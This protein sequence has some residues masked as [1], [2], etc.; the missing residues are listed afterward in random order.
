MSNHHPFGPSS[1]GRRL[2]CPGS[3]KQERDLP[4]VSSTDADLGT[5]IHDHAAK[6]L[7]GDMHVL[8]IEDDD[9]RQVVTRYVEF[10]ES[11][12]PEGAVYDVES[13]Q[14]LVGPGGEVVSFGTID[15]YHIVEGESRQ[16]MVI[17]LKSGHGEISPVDVTLQLGSYLAY[18][19]QRFGLMSAR[20]WI[21]HAR[22]GEA[23]D[24][25]MSRDDV[26]AFIERLEK[27]RAACQADEPKLVVGDHCRFCRANGICS[28]TKAV[29][30]DVAEMSIDSVKRWPAEKVAEVLDVAKIAKR[31]AESIIARARDCLKQDGES[32][33]GWELVEQNGPRSALATNLWPHVAKYL[34]QHEYFNA[35]KI[36]V[37]TVE[38]LVAEKRVES[39]EVKSKAEAVRE[40]K[41]ATSGVVQTPTVRKMQKRKS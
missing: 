18:V 33:P 21:F 27:I 1:L 9:E 6:V 32:I 14:F 22:S 26:P 17:D 41:E 30:D 29:V 25:A 5:K 11:S 16:G 13:R 36:S 10:V 20:G 19:I 35:C 15:Y 23:L 38:K 34:S 28:A 31:A 37:P 4:D 39:G 2:M 3:W 7:N 8:D 24:M 40:F 12:R